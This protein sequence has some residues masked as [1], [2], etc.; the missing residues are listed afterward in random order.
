MLPGGFGRAFGPEES[1]QGAPMCLEGLMEGR[2]GLSARVAVAALAVVVLLWVAGCG[3]TSGDGAPLGSSVAGAIEGLQSA[4]ADEDMKGIC[5]LMTRAAQRQAGNIAHKNP[6]TCVRDVERVIGMID[7]HGGWEGSE[8]PRV[9]GVVGGGDRRIA[10]LEAKDGWRADV[11][12]EKRGAK[13]KVHAFFG[14]S[15]RKLESTEKAMRDRPFPAAAADRVQA[16]TATGKPCPPLRVRRYPRVSGGCVIH[17]VSESE[18][19]RMLTSFG[20]FKFSDCAI[21]YNIRVGPD[22]RTWIDRWEIAGTEETGCS[23]MNPCA[24]PSSPLTYH[25]WKGRLRADGRG[26]F[27]HQV[28]MC[29]RTCAGLFVG[30]WITRFAHDDTG[31]RIA[32]T[33]HGA[34]GFLI[35]GE[36]SAVGK[37]LRLSALAT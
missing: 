15:Q 37:G 32:P 29:M 19:V 13:W 24:M 18:P 28:D 3:G 17:L 35:D 16:T 10:T 8:S 4:F 11:P 9:T 27:I 2:V 7:R 31:W 26:G 1:R 14:T 34:T 36:V 23:D 21:D 33:T 20:D 12:F 22:G 5:A 25:P 30:D 6:T